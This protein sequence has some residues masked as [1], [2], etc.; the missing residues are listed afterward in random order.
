MHRLGIQSTAMSADSGATKG[1]D[2]IRQRF[3]RK[4][5]SKV[6]RSPQHKTVVIF[7]WDDT[8]LCTSWLRSQGYQAGRL[9]DE[10]ILRK[11]A[12]HSKGMLETAIKAAPDH[13]YI[14]TNAMTGW[15][16]QSAAK[17]APEL[18]PV[19]R[20]VPIISAR[21]R[22]ESRFPYDTRQW[23][24]QAFLEVYRNLGA[25]KITNLV[26]LGDADYEI[27]AARIMGE[28]FAEGVVKTV[29]FRPN[30]GVDEHMK[31]VELMAKNLEMVI[32]NAR[33]QK[34]HLAMKRD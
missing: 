23:K 8:L 17:W 19:L 13:T 30:P 10:R 20:K 34:I 2:D 32:G 4:V 11:I 22:F 31:Q 18:L 3:L 26:V 1:K 16:E 6:Q 25:T 7:D 9:A 5:H 27:E 21:D 33:D 14:I 29:K 12:L 15:V 28:E 24:I